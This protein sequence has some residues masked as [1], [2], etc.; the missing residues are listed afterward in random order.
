M[1]SLM[2]KMAIIDDNRRELRYV[3]GALEWEKYQIDVVG[4]FFNPLLALEEIPKL[5]PDIILSD[6]VMPQM[7]GF[8]LVAK[9]LEYNPDLLTV[10]MSCHED[11]EYARAAVDMRACSYLLKPLIIEELEETIAKTVSRLNQRE[12]ERTKNDFMEKIFFQSLETL[13]EQFFFELCNGAF[14]NIQDIHGKMKLLELDRHIIDLICAV[15]IK[16]QQQKEHLQKTEAWKEYYNFFFSRK[17]LS[18]HFSFA[19]SVQ[20]FSKSSEQ[21]SCLLFFPKEEDLVPLKRCI[22]E[23]ATRLVEE[24]TANINREVAVG[25]SNFSFEL[26]QADTLYSQSLAALNTNFFTEINPII[27]YHEIEE[28]QVDA[29]PKVGVTVQEIATGIKALFISGSRD[30]IGAFIDKLF[31][32]N[33]Y[34]SENRIRGLAFTLLTI[35]ELQLSEDG[36]KFSELF[37]DSMGLWNKVLTFDKYYNIKQLLSNVIFETIQFQK[38]QNSSK[39]RQLVSDIKKVIEENYAEP[40]TVSEIAAKV[41]FSASYSNNV[42]RSITGK[43][44]FEYLTEYRIKKAM[45]LLKMPSCKISTVAEQVGYNN[46]SHFS[47]IFKKYVGHTPA[48]YR[49]MM[50]HSEGENNDEQE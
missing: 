8:Q 6:I 30:E 15:T 25:I 26:L 49:R 41:F 18:S 42:F 5:M 35:V 36:I 13:Q 2:Y 11:F 40:I 32:S 14:S 45:H 24:I 46:K 10:F 16:F 50:V 7:N 21:L 22:D 34:H 9:A 43:S 19:K 4:T 29:P 3:Q 1:C 17:M 47:L 12:A 31:S 44:I 39:G 37:P 28:P 23:T 38:K 20:L 33:Y 48:D 27:W